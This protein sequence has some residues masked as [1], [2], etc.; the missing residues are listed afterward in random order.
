MNEDAVAPNLK[1]IPIPAAPDI[2]HAS[3]KPIADWLDRV[4]APTWAVIVSVYLA[5]GFLTYYA[6]SLPVWLVVP[7]GGIVVCW[8]SHLQHELV[9]GHPTRNH[10]FNDLFG[11]L[12]FTL[13]MPYPLYREMHLAHHA[14]PLLTDPEHDTESYFISPKQ[15][16]QMSQPMRWLLLA[17]QTLLGRFL[18]GPILMIFGYWRSEAAMIL[19]GDF[20]HAGAWLLHLALVGALMYWVVFVC[21]MSVWQYVLFFALPGASLGLL[22]SFAEHRPGDSNAERTALIEGSLFIRLL[23]L[24]NNLHAVHHAKPNL[25]WFKIIRDFRTNREKWLKRNGGYYL[26]SYLPLMLK[27][28]IRPKCSPVHPGY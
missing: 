21:G 5:L 27:T 10:R 7:L 24:N 17:N 25:A 22:R 3:G 15:W 6:T 18:I 16:Q 9:H 12:P 2:A 23:F 8:Y 11:L 13:Y 14:T 20:R 4:E 26:R 19:S 1:A 28:F